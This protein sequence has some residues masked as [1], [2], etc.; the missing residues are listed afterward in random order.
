MESAAPE[1]QNRCLVQAVDEE[2]LAEC[3]EEGL[4]DLATLKTFAWVEAKGFPRLS[5]S[6]R[7]DSSND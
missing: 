2:A 4:V 3:V 6:K 7:K 1:I 5:I